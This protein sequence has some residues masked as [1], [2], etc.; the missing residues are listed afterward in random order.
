MLNRDR[1]SIVV[2]VNSIRLLAPENRHQRLSWKIDSAT[3]S[4]VNSTPARCPPR[5]H[6]GSLHVPSTWRIFRETGFELVWY[7][8]GPFANNILGSILS[9]RNALDPKNW[10]WSWSHPRNSPRHSVASVNSYLNKKNYVWVCN[11][12]WEDRKI[13]LPRFASRL[14]L[15]TERIRGWDSN[16]KWTF[17][18]SIV[19]VLPSLRILAHVVA[20]IQ[21]IIRGR[22]RKMAAHVRSRKDLPLPTWR[23]STM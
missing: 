12:S 8:L 22:R 2:Q 10:F 7:I 4:R 19:D 21:K 16:L 17:S 20:P 15:L 9:L 3:R 6:E 23:E 11:I 14:R 18:F 13:L 5:S 1:V